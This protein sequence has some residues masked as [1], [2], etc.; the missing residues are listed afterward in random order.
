MRAVNPFETPLKFRIDH[1][2]ARI[3]ARQNYMTGEWVKVEPWVNEIHPDDT[4]WF[5][6][7][8]VAEDEFDYKLK[9]AG[10]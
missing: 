10:I 3:V 9:C 2:S 8:W 4:D 1:T 5:E 7:M 6:R